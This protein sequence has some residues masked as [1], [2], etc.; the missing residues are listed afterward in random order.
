[1]LIFWRGTFYSTSRG[2]FQ[3]N[4]PETNTS[5]NLKTQDF[6]KIEPWQCKWYQTAVTPGYKNKFR[7]KIVEN[8][9]RAQSN[10]NEAEDVPHTLVTNSALMLQSDSALTEP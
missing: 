7:C 9:S 10:G 3:S 2:C 8:V 4:L 5:P 6:C 1:M